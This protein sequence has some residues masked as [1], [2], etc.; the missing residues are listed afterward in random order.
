M[1]SLIPEES[2]EGIDVES[3]F[4]KQFSIVSFTL[5]LCSPSIPLIDLPERLRQ[6]SISGVLV[7]T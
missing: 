1:K 4:V 7:V 6:E 5:H 3:M 2:G